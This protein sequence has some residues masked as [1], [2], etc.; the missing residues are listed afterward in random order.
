MISMTWPQYQR[1]ECSAFIKVKLSRME[2]ELLSTLL[3]RRPAPLTI[4][5]LI[6]A[7][8]PD[9]NAE[10]DFAVQM[11]HRVIGRLRRKLGSHYIERTAMGYRLA[12]QQTTVDT[13]G[14]P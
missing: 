12:R 5:D 7:I 8:Y 1:R 10:P 14:H 3:A 4:N 13:N 11:T 6:E 2:A 9:P